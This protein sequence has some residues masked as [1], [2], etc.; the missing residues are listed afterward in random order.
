M[1]RYAL[2]F[3]IIALIAA[4]FGFGGIATG[5]VVIAKVIFYIFLILLILSLMINIIRKA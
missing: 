2:I 4:V 5:A 3:F 1:L